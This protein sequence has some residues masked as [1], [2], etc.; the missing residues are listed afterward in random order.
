MVSAAAITQV[1]FASWTATGWMSI[2][3][4]FSCSFF[5]V[6]VGDKPPEWLRMSLNGRFNECPTSAGW[7]EHSLAQGGVNHGHP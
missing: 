6:S 3:T 1:A 2:P 5:R 7:V 4:T